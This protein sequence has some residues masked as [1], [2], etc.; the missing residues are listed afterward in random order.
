MAV[1]GLTASHERGEL[2]RRGGASCRH[3]GCGADGPSSPRWTMAL[4]QMLPKIFTYQCV[5]LR[6]QATL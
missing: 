1:L 5:S 4:I 6:N 2:G 3:T